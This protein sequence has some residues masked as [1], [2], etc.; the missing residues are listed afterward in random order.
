[1][2]DIR[3]ICKGYRERKVIARGGKTD[4]ANKR[5]AGAKAEIEKV[6]AIFNRLDDMERDLVMKAYVDEEYQWYTKRAAKY[7]CGTSTLY[8]VLKRAGEKVENLYDAW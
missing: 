5:Y 4:A 3:Q 1:M 8:R 6:E 7:W 2:K